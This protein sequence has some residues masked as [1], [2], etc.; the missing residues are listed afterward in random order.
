M[1][2]EPINLTPKPE[3]SRKARWSNRLGMWSLVLFF[4]PCLLP[5]LRGLVMDWGG[6]HVHP[7]SALFEA[8]LIGCIVIGV[9]MNVAAM[10]LGVWALLEIRASAGRLEGNGLAQAGIGGG[11]VLMILVALLMPAVYD[12][13]EAAR[14]TQCK[15]NMKQV[16]LAF[17]NYHDAFKSFPP[18]AIC[19][20][21]GKPLLS[22]RVAILPFIEQHKSYR[23][24]HL[25]EPW[26]SPHNLPLADRMPSNLRCPSDF[27]SSANASTYV[28]VTGPGTFFPH[29]GQT[30]IKAVT[31]GTSLTVMA[32]E[33]LPNHAPWTKPDDPVLDQSAAGRGRFSSAHAGGWQVLMGDG[34][35][36]YISEKTKPTTLRAILT[37]AGREVVDEDDF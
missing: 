25:D 11:I 6:V 1:P 36:R 22:W 23:E 7:H 8:V 32:G 35:C 13:R 2:D 9:V 27:K 34:T 12:A 37:I 16:G 5:L 19:D 24:F 18:Y 20:A 29:D 28:I 17:H 30:T 4:C 33:I 14:R 3:V 10:V 26:D 21:D 15:C 31:D